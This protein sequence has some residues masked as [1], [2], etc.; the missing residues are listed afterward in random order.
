MIALVKEEIIKAIK[1][2]DRE[3]VNQGYRHIFKLNLSDV[4][5]N[6]EEVTKRAMID[7]DVAELVPEKDIKA[8]CYNRV[9]QIFTSKKHQQEYATRDAKQARR[10]SYKGTPGKNIDIHFPMQ[11]YGQKGIKAAKGGGTTTSQ[12]TIN[13]QVMGAMQDECLNKV[14]KDI[15]KQFLGKGTVSG[16]QMKGGYRRSGTR[17]GDP[18][19]KLSA[20]HGTKSNR[21]TVA[22]FGGAEKMKENTEANFDSMEEKDFEKAISA[23]TNIN[24]LYQKVYETYQEAFYTEVGLEQALDMS[25]KDMRKNLTVEINYDP[26]NKNATMKDYDSRELQKFILEHTAVIEREV[27]D[28]L[29][30]EELQTSRS[31]KDHLVGASAKSVIQNMFPHKTK[32][33]M[34]YKVNKKLLSFKDV[35]SKQSTKFG[36]KKT[37]PNKSTTGKTAVRAAAGYKGLSRGMG[38]VEKKAGQNP[39]ALK[40]LLNEILPPAVAANMVAPALR[41]RTGR[42]ANSVRV[43]NV[44]QGPRGGNTMIEATYRTN[45]YETFAP[46]GK[47]YTPQRDPERLIKRTIRQVASGLIG[48]RFGIDI[49]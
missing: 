20:L 21:T 27:T 7:N 39:M 3:A 48:A 46:G 17:P 23:G 6:M 40:S 13:Q 36:S 11:S 24:N 25:I 22:A 19:I 32:P 45:P 43:D 34:R 41:Y 28:A 26:A 1:A 10:L 14:R 38:H 37:S 5:K 9:K 4:M 42:F 47:Q 29:T 16:S 18:Y 31:P 2:A 49:Q 30:N 12:Y 33:D 44:T 8:I 35:K 15:N